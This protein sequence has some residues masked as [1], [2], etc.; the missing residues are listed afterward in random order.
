VFALFLFCTSLFVLDI[1]AQKAG[2]KKPFYEPSKISGEQYKKLSRQMVLV[3]TNDWDSISGKLQRY[4]RANSKAKWK[5][6]GE[7]FEIVVG[8]SGLAWGVGLHQE[9]KEGAIKKEGDGKSPAGIFKLS[10]AFGF[11]DK[12]ET[13]WLKIPY[14]FVEES[15]ECVDDTKSNHYNRIVDKFKVGDFDWDSSEKMLKVGEQYR[16]GIVVAHNAEP[17]KKGDGSCIFLHI[18]ADNK[19]GTSGCTAMENANIETLL[20]WL[21][22]KKKPLLVQLPQSE[23]ERLQKAW[24]LPFQK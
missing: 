14:T 24:K 22:E 21:D 4:E 18:R 13:G 15:T 20:K 8:R 1:N 16:W 5:A 10:S 17:P 3:V 11:A 12:K 2:N 19:T 23:Y 9:Q 6:V 7:P